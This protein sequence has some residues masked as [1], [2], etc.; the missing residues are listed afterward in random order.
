MAFNDKYYGGNKFPSIK[1]PPALGRDF[2]RSPLGRPTLGQ[3]N[4]G[5]ATSGDNRG[6]TPPP[7]LADWFS[8]GGMNNPMR[9]L[10]RMPAPSTSFPVQRQPQLPN[11]SAS[12]PPNYQPGRSADPAP[13][14]QPWS[15]AVNRQTPLPAAGPE[16][17]WNIWGQNTD[18]LNQVAQ[19]WLDNPLWND[20]QWSTQ[21]NLPPW[22]RNDPDNRLHRY[23]R[24]SARKQAIKDNFYEITRRYKEAKRAAR[25]NE[26]QTWDPANNVWVDPPPEPARNWSPRDGWYPA[27]DDTKNRGGY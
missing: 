9:Q 23:F 5:N 15:P 4:G 27:S 21:A 12:A 22:E 6:L 24:E 26:N 14:A 19:H 1:T 17:R 3:P 13:G 11:Q 16:I 10:G 25:T 18:Q 20:R 8:K 2:G 7:G